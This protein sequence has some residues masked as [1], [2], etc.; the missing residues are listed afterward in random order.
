MFLRNFSVYLRVHT[1]LQLRRPIS[2]VSF[3]MEGTDLLLLYSD[4]T[5]TDERPNPPVVSMLK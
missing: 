2:K 5:G 3:R 1:A 4:A